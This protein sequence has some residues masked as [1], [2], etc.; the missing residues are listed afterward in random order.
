MRD[1]YTHDKSKSIQRVE[2]ER[3]TVY[4]ETRIDAEIGHLIRAQD[5]AA[6]QMLAYGDE[7]ARRH[8]LR[9]FGRRATFEFRAPASWWQHFKLALRTRSEMR[10]VSS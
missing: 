8:I 2:L 10:R 9:T 1:D 3:V 4:S 5:P 7:Y 6:M